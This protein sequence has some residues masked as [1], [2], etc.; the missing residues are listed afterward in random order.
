MGQR[1]NLLL[2]FMR[3]AA[4]VD[5]EFQSAGP[6]DAVL[7]AAA[8]HHLGIIISF[9]DFQ[10]TPDR[11]QLDDIV[12]GALSLGADIVKVATRTDTQEQLQ[13]LLD[14][15]ERNHGAQKVVAMGIGKLGGISR[16]EFARRGCRLNYA[17]LGSPATAGQLSLRGLRQALG[18]SGS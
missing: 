9:H 18:D 4:W 3:R 8:V 14:L 2:E 11:S 1:R 6:L 12:S 13:T 15:F 16:V 5:V 10:T 7:R 17:H